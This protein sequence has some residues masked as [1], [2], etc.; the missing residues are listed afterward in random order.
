MPNFNNCKTGI[1][2][3]TTSTVRLTDKVVIKDASIAGVTLR[4]KSYLSNPGISGSTASSFDIINCARGFQIET[5]HVDI[6]NAKISDTRYGFVAK[7]SS[8]FN[9][10]NSQITSNIHGS[11]TG[12]AYGMYVSDASVGNLF[13]SSI[14]GYAGG[15]GSLTSGNFV[16]VKAAKVF[17]GAT[18]QLT[19]ANTTA[20]GADNIGNVY[21]DIAKG[22]SIIGGDRL[23]EY[24]PPGDLPE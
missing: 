24:L 2:A 16:V 4:N 20:L 12:Q 11:T 10:N 18:A 7:D 1:Y 23:V 14:T 3:S 15:T 22:N 13:D 17:V 5:S 19:Q 8:S 21:F 9:F 6:S